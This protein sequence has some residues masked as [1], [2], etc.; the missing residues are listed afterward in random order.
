MSLSHIL[1]SLLQAVM[2]SIYGNQNNF[3]QAAFIDPYIQIALPLKDFLIAMS[4]LCL[5][6]YQGR[7]K[8][9]QHK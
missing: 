6:H 8:V 3:L 7:R 1:I 5:Y 9:E 2:Q 4:L